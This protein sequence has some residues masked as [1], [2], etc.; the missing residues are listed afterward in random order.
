[1]LDMLRPWLGL[2]VGVMLAV[3]GWK[4]LTKPNAYVG[5]GI[6]PASNP[7]TVKWFGIVG[8]IIGI[9]NA[10]VNLPHLFSE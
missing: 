1:M 5:V 10:S 9:D 8:L 4:L 7:R 6:I 3:N 2:A